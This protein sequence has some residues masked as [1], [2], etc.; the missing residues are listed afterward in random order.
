MNQPGHPNRPGINP[1]PMQGPMGPM[2]PMQ[3]PMGSRGIPGDPKDHPDHENTLK[4]AGPLA[5]GVSEY[6]FDRYCLIFF[7]RSALLG[8]KKSC[9]GSAGGV[10]LVVA[11]PVADFFRFFGL[12][13]AIRNLYDFL[14]DFY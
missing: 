2:A 6:V 14:I 3:G 9:A 13:K 5:L 12:P 1:V 4:F 7:E 10:S 8:Q 11:V